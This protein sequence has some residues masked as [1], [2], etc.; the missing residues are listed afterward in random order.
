MTKHELHEPKA[1][2]FSLRFGLIE[3]R[4]SLAVFGEF[5]GCS[6]IAREAFA[7][8]QS[9][10]FRN[11]VKLNFNYALIVRGEKSR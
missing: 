7:I 4:F 6:G 9:C 5:T 3:F 10:W 1:A 8:T 2:I 11:S